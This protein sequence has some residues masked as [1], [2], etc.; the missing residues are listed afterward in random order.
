MAGTGQ[1]TIDGDAS[2]V[3]DAAV[4]AGQQITFSGSSNSLNLQDSPNF[5]GTIAGFGG[6]DS[7][8]VQ[9]I[10]F[11]SAD[12]SLNYTPNQAKTGGVLTRERWYQKRR[13]QLS[14][15]LHTS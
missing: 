6:N 12:F 5:A 4:S 3:F 11:N 9:D 14:W 13:D 15:K 8:H 2:L 10:N 1:E 7:I